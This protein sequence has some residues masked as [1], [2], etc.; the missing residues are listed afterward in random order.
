MSYEFYKPNTKR[1]ADFLLLKK[2]CFFGYCCHVDQGTHSQDPLY[3][4]ESLIY[5]D[6][7]P[8]GYAW[9]VTFCMCVMGV[10]LKF[11]NITPPQRSKV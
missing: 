11:L 10:K 6:I 8:G 2:V 7:K 1:G 5:K 4:L 3:G 9:L